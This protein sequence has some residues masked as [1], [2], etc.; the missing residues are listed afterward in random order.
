ML[1][2]L[3]T[4]RY[5]RK[6]NIFKKYGIFKKNTKKKNNKKLKVFQTIVAIF[7]MNSIDFSLFF[8]INL[9]ILIISI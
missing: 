6:K 4:E 5:Q 9:F 8:L 1:M 3:K 7:K 2:T